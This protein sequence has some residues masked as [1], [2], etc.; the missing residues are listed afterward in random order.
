MVVDWVRLLLLLFPLGIS[1]FLSRMYILKNRNGIKHIYIQVTILLL[2]WFSILLLMYM[3]YL[4]QHFYYQIY[5]VYI[6]L[7]Y[8]LIIEP[9]IAYVFL[10]HFNKGDSMVFGKYVL[11]S[12]VWTVI[13][14]FFAV[15]IMMIFFINNNPF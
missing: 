13:L 10:F 5:I 14:D 6:W 7:G 1:L 8:Y 4:I 11:T 2:Y 9:I 12:V 15:T 3:D